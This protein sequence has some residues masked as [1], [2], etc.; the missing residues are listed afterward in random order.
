M[1]QAGKL[2]LSFDANNHGHRVLYYSAL[3]NLFPSF[4]ASSIS[5]C[6]LVACWDAVRFGFPV[7][8][9]L[10]L[11]LAMSDTHCLPS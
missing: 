2:L 10:G 9:S 5:F 8:E 7:S 6:A 1:V 4:T 3:H 11:L